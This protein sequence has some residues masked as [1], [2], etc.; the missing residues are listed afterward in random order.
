[1]NPVVIL[2]DGLA[3]AC[4]VGALFAGSLSR[5]STVYRDQGDHARHRSYRR[6]ARITFGCACGAL[7][8]AVALLR[9]TP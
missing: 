3:Y 9:S 1:M 2:A 8:V 5:Q 6:A 4:L 7:G